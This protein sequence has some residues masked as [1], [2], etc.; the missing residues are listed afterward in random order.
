LSADDFILKDYQEHE[1]E[2]TACMLYNYS[3]RM[4]RLARFWF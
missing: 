4:K 3:I 1:I 2:A